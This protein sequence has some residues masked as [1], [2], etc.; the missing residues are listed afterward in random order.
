MERGFIQKLKDF[1]TLPFRALTIFYEDRWG[2]SSLAS[3]RFDYVARE[4]QGYCLDIGCGPNN[5]FVSN[6]LNGAGVGIDLLPY[7]GLGPDNVREDLT[8]L[9]FE[10]STFETVTFIANINHVPRSQRDAELAEAHRC[11]KP[12]GNIVI[13]MGNPVSEVLVHKV[14]YLHD[15]VFGTDHDIDNARG[16]DKEEAY[17]L[18]NSEIIDRLSRA[19]FSD[20]SKKYFLTQWG[21]N[22]LI[23]GWKAGPADPGC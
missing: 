21:L 20:F 9:D 10:D 23:V 6:F 15:R 22:H 17:Y 4:V 18:T 1:L 11:V 2:L 12:G 3:E 8:D 13:T 16:M 5:R 14:V 7:E 19:G